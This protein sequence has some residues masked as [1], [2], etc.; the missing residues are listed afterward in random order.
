MFIKKDRRSIREIIFDE[1]TTD[2]KS[3]DDDKPLT[4]LKLS[5]RIA[6][7]EGSLIPLCQ[8]IYVSKLACLKVLNLYDNALEDLSSIGY[9]A[10]TQLEDL[11]LG[12]NKL[13][14]IPTEVIS[15]KLIGITT[16]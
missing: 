7:F 16:L 1:G 12:C 15:Y 14:S 13:R 6:E 8:D 5:K 10:F 4:I 11:N 3:K 9:F 2:A